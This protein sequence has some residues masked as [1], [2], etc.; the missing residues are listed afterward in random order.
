MFGYNYG[1]FILEL[2]DNTEVGTILGYTTDDGKISYKDKALCI[3]TLLSVY[4]NKLE[5]VYSCNI[6]MKKKDIPAFEY[7]TET[8]V[9]P[10]IKTAKPR[11]IIPVFP[12]LT[13]NLIP[14]R[15]FVTQ[16]QSL[17]S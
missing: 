5:P 3:D 13:V 12:V 2:N 6:P 1:A 9:S 11:V 14:Q 16:E 17:R 15:Y 7:K 4:E 10:A 8:R